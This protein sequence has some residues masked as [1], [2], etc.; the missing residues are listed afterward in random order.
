MHICLRLIL[1]KDKLLMVFK[2]NARFATTKLVV[3]VKVEKL[4]VN[5]LWSRFFSNLASFFRSKTNLPLINTKRRHTNKHGYLR[6]VT[7]FLTCC[8]SCKK[9]VN[10]TIFRNM[11]GEIKK[12]KK[13][14]FF[15]ISA[16]NLL[17]FDCVLSLQ[18][19]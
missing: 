15:F 17:R 7:F 8:T 13:R 2:I 19:K 16:A 9:C 1:I 10:A 4:T 18:G 14:K 5:E 12:T 3:K 11:C 6:I